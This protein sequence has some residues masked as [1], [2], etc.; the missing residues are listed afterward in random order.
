MTSQ[1]GKYTIWTNPADIDYLKNQETGEIAQPKICA[2]WTLSNAYTQTMPGKEGLL[3][4]KKGMHLKN[5]Q[6]RMNTV[7][8][9][10]NLRSN[11]IQTL[12]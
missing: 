10:N 9:E 4:G 12:S 11:C 8:G 2:E 1:C 6:E 5:L 7:N 3:I